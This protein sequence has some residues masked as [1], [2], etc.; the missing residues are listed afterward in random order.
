MDELIGKRYGT[1]LF[2]VAREHQ[3]LDRMEEDIRLV[4]RTIKENP[5]FIEILLLPS[6]LLE[7][8]KDLMKEALAGK[9]NQDL[10]SLLLLT[11][12]KARQAQLEKI[13]EYAL[14]AVQ[15]EKGVL[16][17]YVTSAAELTAEEKEALKV[18]LSKQTGKQ[19]ELD[20]RIDAALIGGMIIRVKDRLVDHTI[21]GEL[22]K[23]A[24]QLNAVK[25]SN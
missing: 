25:I 15:E 4:L 3:E 11:V 24:K 16:T 9:I 12:D 1:A 13:L 21:R 14:Q 23:L 8:K 5:G 18:K 10:M 7:K 2:E 17:A 6:V 22:H 19:I 20:C